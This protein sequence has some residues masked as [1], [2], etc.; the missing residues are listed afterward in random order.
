MSSDSGL[1]HRTR[2]RAMRWIV[3]GCARSKSAA[4][5]TSA[6]MTWISLP[7]SRRKS[8]SKDTAVPPL[9]GRNSSVTIRNGVFTGAGFDTSQRR[10]ELGAEAG[11]VAAVEPATADEMN[12]LGHA[13]FHLV[14]IGVL[15]V[16]QNDRVRDVGDDDV[17]H[18][19][20]AAPFGPLVADGGSHLPGDRLDEFPL[21][22]A[23]CKAREA[24]AAPHIVQGFEFPKLVEVALGDDLNVVLAL[25]Y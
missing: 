19:L 2:F 10:N 3:F 17:R 23:P 7:P 11:I 16:R 5:G 8:S 1:S 4:P 24:R 20:L 18:D 12:E 25:R 15:G 6:V 21:E 9:V 14:A 22:R 13:L